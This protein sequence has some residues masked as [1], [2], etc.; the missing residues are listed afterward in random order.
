MS[1]LYW[2]INNIYK[3]LIQNKQHKSFDIYHTEQRYVF[4][5]LLPVV[6]NKTKKT[7]YIFKW[8]LLN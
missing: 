5:N 6:K 3:F 1:A 2:N 4:V 7:V 8:F